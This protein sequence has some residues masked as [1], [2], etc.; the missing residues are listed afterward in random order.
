MLVHAAL[1][2]ESRLARYLLIRFNREGPRLKLEPRET[3]AGMLGT[4]VRHVNRTLKTLTQAGAITVRYKTVE[5]LRPSR[6]ADLIGEPFDKR[7]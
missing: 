3:L 1:P 5:I 4:S 7:T 6:L 2:L